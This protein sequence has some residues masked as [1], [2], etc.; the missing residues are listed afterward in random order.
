[1]TIDKTTDPF[2]CPHSNPSRSGLKLSG[3]RWSISLPAV[4][5]RRRIMLAAL[6][7][8]VALASQ[9][10]AQPSDDLAAQVR[11]LVSQL[12][13]AELAARNSAEEELLGLGPA[14]LKLLP[15]D[16]STSAELEQ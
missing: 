3:C 9:V 8:A 2:Q 14:V 1:M 5:R 13:A 4:V 11:R 6:L 15:A 16:A 7:L 12:D 10:E